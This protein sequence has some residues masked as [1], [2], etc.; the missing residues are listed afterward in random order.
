[1]LKSTGF[2]KARLPMVHTGSF[3]PLTLS[4]GAAAALNGTSSR[5]VKGRPRT[6]NPPD[7]SGSGAVYADE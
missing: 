3:N 7:Y 1:M 6:V 2:A 4:P 5:R